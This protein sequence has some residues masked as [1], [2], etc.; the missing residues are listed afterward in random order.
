VPDNEKDQNDAGDGDD[1]FF[2]NRRAIKGCQNIHVTIRCR[3]IGVVSDY[4]CG[5]ERQE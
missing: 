3:S 1:H 4:G 2:S 5:L